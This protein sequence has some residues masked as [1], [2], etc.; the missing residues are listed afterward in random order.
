MNVRYL[1]EYYLSDEKIR[2]DGETNQLIEELMQQSIKSLKLI[3]AALLINTLVIVLF[4]KYPSVW[5]I[6]AVSIGIFTL[7]S[8]YISYM[9][10][11]MEIET[12][13]KREILLVEHLDAVYH[14]I[15]TK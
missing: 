10:R 2:I 5:G 9:A 11:E 14:E 1:Y 12:Y 4:L 8:V 6:L 15:T 7:I 13:M 3:F